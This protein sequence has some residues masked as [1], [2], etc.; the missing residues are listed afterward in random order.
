V[1]PRIGFVLCGFWGRHV[2]VEGLIGFVLQNFRIFFPE[3]LSQRQQ[4]L[5]D[6]ESGG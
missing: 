5:L 6:L 4:I 1:R 3:I 2:D